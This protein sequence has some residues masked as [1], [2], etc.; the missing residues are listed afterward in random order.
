M[1]AT[2]N[3]PAEMAT[4]D[5]FAA[6]LRASLREA[7]VASLNSLDTLINNDGY[8]WLE[9]YMASIMDT[10]TRYVDCKT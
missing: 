4:V 6:S 1:A 5:D 10:K 2:S 7:A 3:Q 9:G 8:D